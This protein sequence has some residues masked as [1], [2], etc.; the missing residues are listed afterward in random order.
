MKVKRKFA[1]LSQWRCVSELCCGVNSVSM[2]QGL[3]WWSNGPY[4]DDKIIMFWFFMPF[5]IYRAGHLNVP[6]QLSKDQ[7]VLQPPTLGKASLF[8]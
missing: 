1:E 8:T 6:V 5:W 7:F 4:Y 3:M 2:S